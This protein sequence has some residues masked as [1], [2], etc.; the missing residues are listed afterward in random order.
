[1]RRGIAVK[2]SKREREEAVVKNP[3]IASKQPISALKYANEQ[4]SL[5]VIVQG[6]K[7]RQL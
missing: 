6:A 2:A 4:C 7:E 5:S 1:M 3:I